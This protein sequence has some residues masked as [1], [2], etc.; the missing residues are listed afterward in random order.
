MTS[1]LEC[2]GNTGIPRPLGCWSPEHGSVTVNG[3]CIYIHYKHMRVST[4]STSYVVKR[5]KFSFALP[6]VIRSEIIYSFL[7]DVEYLTL[8]S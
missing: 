4:F 5:T 2:V 8:C 6:V 1:P 3:V 7:N